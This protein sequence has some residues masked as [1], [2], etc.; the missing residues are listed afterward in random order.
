MM[1]LYLQVISGSGQGQRLDVGQE[2]V[3]GRGEGV[4]DL[5]GDVELSRR[6][7]RFSHAP[8]GAPVVEDLGSTNGTL[9][10]GRPI[11]E[12]TV[13]KVGDR[14]ELGQTVL[15]VRSDDRT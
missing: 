3:V 6:H 4:T 13:L 15:E 9:V 8:D 12:P 10:N 7:A 14:V 11:S 5:G 2:F 1:V